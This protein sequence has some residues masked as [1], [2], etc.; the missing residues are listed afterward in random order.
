MMRQKLSFTC[1][2]SMW[3]CVI[4][5]A[6]NVRWLLC[7][8]RFSHRCRKWLWWM[9]LHLSN[10]ALA[11]LAVQF[12]AVL[13]SSFDACPVTWWSFLIHPHFQP[14]INDSTTFWFNINNFWRVK[15]SKNSK[16]REQCSYIEQLLLTQSPHT[17]ENK[18]KEKIEKENTNKI[19]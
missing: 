18:M 13:G 7:H 1:C 15:K 8:L 6:F 2:C 9:Q 4:V 3:V 5:R 17:N 10:W 12:Q 19:R 16:N 14:T 11:R